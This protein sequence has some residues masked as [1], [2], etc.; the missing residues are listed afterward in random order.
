MTCRP[1]SRGST[2]GPACCVSCSP[3]T[4]SAATQADSGDFAMAFAGDTHGGQICLPLPGRRI[5]LSDL[6]AR[7]A[8]GEYDAD[9][10]R[11][12]VTRGV[13]TSLLP[14][15]AF[16]RPEVVVFHVRTGGTE[17]AP[18]SRARALLAAL[19][20]VAVLAPLALAACGNA[21][22]FTGLYWEPSTGR[23]IEIKHVG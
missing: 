11:L 7:F 9:G 6:H 18:A 15:R 3:T 20:L 23:R 13:G 1:C 17:A 12:Y 4:P 14:F 22:P 21:D 8:E 16:C 2:A 5:M 19:A 10:R